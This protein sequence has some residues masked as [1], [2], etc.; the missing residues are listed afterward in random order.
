M[1]KEKQKAVFEFIFTHKNSP[2]IWIANALCTE[3]GVP[4]GN[5]CG[6]PLPLSLSEARSILVLL[7][8]K[9][10]VTEAGEIFGEPYYDVHHAKDTEWRELIANTRDIGWLEKHRPTILTSVG[11][12]LLFSASI[13]YTTYLQKTTERKI[14][15]LQKVMPKNQPTN[16]LHYSYGTNNPDKPKK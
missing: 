12:F 3:P 1:T 9:G 4:N 15:D 2:D 6:F 16:S 10:L 13:I 14:D 8:E 11:A 7:K 5:Q